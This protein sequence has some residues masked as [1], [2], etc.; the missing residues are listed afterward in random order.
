M[1]LLPLITAEL[2]P[3]PLQYRGNGDLVLDFGATSTSIVP[4]LAHAVRM[5]NLVVIPT[6][7]D[8]L[9]LKTTVDTVNFIQE[10]DTPITI[11]IKNLTDNKKYLKIHTY[12]KNGLTHCPAIYSIRT[13]T[14]FEHVAL[15]GEEWLLNVHNQKGEYKLNKTSKA[16]H[17]VY[18]AI[19][20]IGRSNATTDD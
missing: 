14:L 6:L 2:K 17:R 20:S 19:A 3:K 8:T 5:S 9:S 1:T 15:D 11:I 12:L 18:E 16:H 7:T 4:K 13:I 10:P